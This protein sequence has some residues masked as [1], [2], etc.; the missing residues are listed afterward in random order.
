MIDRRQ[1]R[2][3]P[4]EQTRYGKLLFGESLSD[5]QGWDS[6]VVKKEQGGS[7]RIKSILGGI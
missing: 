7:E 5:Y 4:D 3:H 1:A 6:D 2:D